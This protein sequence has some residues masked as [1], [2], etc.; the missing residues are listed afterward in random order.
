MKRFCCLLLPF[1]CV[2]IAGMTREGARHWEIVET[3][4]EAAN[5][6]EHAFVKVEEQFY[7]LG[8]RRMQAVDIYDPAK[9]EWSKGSKPPAERHHFQALAYEAEAAG[10]KWWM[11]EGPLR[12]RGG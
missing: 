9:K 6:H 1:V 7:V 2:A 8:G 10:D 5:R 3:K 12:E 11:V 4:G